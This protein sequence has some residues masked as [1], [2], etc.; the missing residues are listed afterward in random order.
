MKKKLHTLFLIIFLLAGC[1]SVKEEGN[2]SGVDAGGP[3]AGQKIDFDKVDMLVVVD[4]SQSMEEEQVRLAAS[5]R[6]LLNSL[7]DPPA[8]W[9]IPPVDNIRIGVVTSD[10][11]IDTSEDITNCDSCCPCGDRGRIQCYNMIDGCECTG[12]PWLE[13]TPENPNKTLADDFAC[14]A[15]VGTDG[16][17]FEMQL[18]AASYALQRVDQ[19]EFLRGDN[20]LLVIIAVS[21]EDDCSVRCG[22]EFWFRPEMSMTNPDL[23][24][25]CVTSQDMLIAVDDIALNLMKKGNDRAGVIPDAVLFAGFIGVPMIDNCQGNGNVIDGCLDVAQMEFVREEDEEGRGYPRAACISEQTDTDT[26]VPV[27][28]AEPGRRFVELAQDF[29]ENGYIYSICNEDWSPAMKDIAR[30]IATILKGE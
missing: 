16:C 24:I 27:T 6:K 19:K 17:S 26:A 15:S 22:A 18:F 23:N 21:D 7:V 30:R 12:D 25:F 3:D 8:D 13:S 1:I 10:L 2:D 29:G 9:K 11:G 4:N 14:L 20:A 28:S 5:F